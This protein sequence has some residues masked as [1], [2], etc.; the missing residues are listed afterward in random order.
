MP[1]L[2][3]ILAVVGAMMLI[4][5]SAAH[6]LLGWPSLRGR[7]TAASVPAD[8]LAGLAMGWHFGGVAM[9]ALGVIALWAAAER[10][11]RAANFALAVIGAAYLAFGMGAAATL[12]WDPFQLIFLIPGALLAAAAALRPRAGGAAA[13]DAS[14]SEAA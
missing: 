3:T 9:L 1:S 8:L 7:L 11:S 13:S 4:A 6:S 2:R 5:S 12:G 10:R 14:R